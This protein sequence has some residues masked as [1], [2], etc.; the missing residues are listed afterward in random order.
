MTKREALS[1]AADIQELMFKKF[2]DQLDTWVSREKEVVPFLIEK[3]VLPSDYSN[4]HQL[5]NIINDA[6]TGPLR[7]RDDALWFKA[8]VLDGVPGYRISRPP[9]PVELLEEAHE[10]IKFAFKRAQKNMKGT[11][12][13]MQ[14]LLT[15]LSIV[16]TVTTSAIIG[17]IDA[18]KV[19]N[20]QEP[21]LISEMQKL[22]QKRMLFLEAQK[23]TEASQSSPSPEEATIEAVLAAVQKLQSEVESIKDALAAMQRSK[24]KK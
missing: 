11:P 17:A 18:L 2:Q 5:H 24:G 14:A 12:E 22:N 13:T 7:T 16:Q 21:A 15:V 8:S 23:V 1:T 10:T 3:G 19:F 6:N 4:P 20:E 9:G